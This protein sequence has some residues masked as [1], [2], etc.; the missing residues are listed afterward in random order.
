M[1][2]Y[3][4]NTSGA[5]PYQGFAF[6]YRES[7]MKIQGNSRSTNEA[8][9]VWDKTSGDISFTRVSDSFYYDGNFLIDFTNIVNTFTA[10]LTFGANIDNNGNPRRYSKVNLSNMNVSLQYLYTEIPNITY[11]MLHY[12]CSLLRNDIL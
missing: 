4:I 8:S 1:F 11:E 12:Q 7:A 10:P 2:L 5:A 3:V 9:E 6:Q